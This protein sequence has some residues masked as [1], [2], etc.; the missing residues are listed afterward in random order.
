MKTKMLSRTMENKW[1]GMR[2]NIE[3]TFNV[4]QAT[5]TRDALAKETFSRLFDN[6]VKVSLVLI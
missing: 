3:C 1:G 6:L 2:E 5:Y 4:E